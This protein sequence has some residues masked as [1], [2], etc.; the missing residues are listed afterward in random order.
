MAKFIS[1]EKLHVYSPKVITGITCIRQSETKLGECLNILSNLSDLSAS[2]SKFV[3]VGLPEDVGVR[4][5][6]G[7]GGAH[8]AWGPTLKALLNIQSTALFTGTEI[9]LLGYLDFTREMAV[10]DQ[11]DLKTE[12]GLNQIR[13]LVA[14]IDDCV[15]NLILQLVQAEK[16]PII[17]GGGHNNSYPILKALSLHHQQAINTIN[18]DAHADFRAMEGRHSGNGFSYAMHEGYLSKYAVIGLH[19]NYNSHSIVS[20]LAQ[21]TKQ[22]FH[23]FFEDNLR[24][25]TTYNDDFGKALQFTRGIGG[26]EIDLDCMAGV[27]SS[28][29]SLTGF[30]VMQV[31]EMIAQTTVQKMAYLHIAEG[32]SELSDGRKEPLIGKL[33]ATLISDFVKAQQ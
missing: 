31:R 11:C 22:I 20:Q 30:S 29:S 24:N 6:L 33:I 21:N 17:I 14:D 12:L 13:E 8:T 18:L 28:A 23:S 10:A 26:L 5:N 2:P 3:L 1:M 9:A 7:I 16:M 19:E 32:A 25:K 15:F 4:A 27:L